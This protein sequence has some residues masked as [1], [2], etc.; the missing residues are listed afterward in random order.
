V[1]REEARV[2]AL[3]YDPVDLA[4]PPVTP[5]IREVAPMILV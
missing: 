1:S 3:D 4:Y 2:E 5:V